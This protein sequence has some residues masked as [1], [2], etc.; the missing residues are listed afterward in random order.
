MSQMGI[1]F[2]KEL[3]Q[4][5]LSCH[6]LLWIDYFFNLNKSNEKISDFSLLEETL[7][8]AAVALLWLQGPP[9]SHTGGCHLAH[10]PGC[11][12][13]VHPIVYFVQPL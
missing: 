9:P 5:P 7:C 13:P 4:S 12:I 11:A 2:P 8:M 10:S 1:F 6:N 3:F